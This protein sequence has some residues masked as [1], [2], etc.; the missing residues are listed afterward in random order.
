MFDAQG[1]VVLRGRDFE[2]DFLVCDVPAPG[3][4]SV[5]T[6]A[7]RPGTAGTEVPAPHPSQ[8]A[9]PELS[10]SESRAS[11]MWSRDFSP[12]VTASDV[13]PG[14][15][16]RRD[17]DP[18][19]AAPEE[20]AFKALTMGLR[21]YVR[22]CGFSRV[23]LGLSGGIDSAVTA[24]L[25]PRRLARSTSQV[26]PCPRATHRPAA[27]RTPRRSPATSASATASS[28]STRCSEATWRLLVRCSPGSRPT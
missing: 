18:D 12:G 26:S 1:H 4:G 9:Q 5:F 22:K 6:R 3:G 13:E 21:D 2:E 7:V 24:A 11:P 15:Q 10:R 16:S 8:D 23:V 14:L 19:D 17:T 25:P 27:W 20:Q 28:P